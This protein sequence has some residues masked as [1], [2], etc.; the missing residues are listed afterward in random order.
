M[1][2]ASRTFKCPT[3][4]I[5]VTVCSDTKAHDSIT[6]CSKCDPSRAKTKAKGKKK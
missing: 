1:A 2:N 6:H 4:K 3:C 5:D